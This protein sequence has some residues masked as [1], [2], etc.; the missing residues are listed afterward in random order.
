MYGKV[1]RSPAFIHS[2]NPNIIPEN[3]RGTDEALG[4]AVDL[5]PTL[6]SIAG[7][8]ARPSSTGAIDGI[9]MLSTWKSGSNDSPRK[10]MVYNIDPIGMA[11]TGGNF[12]TGGTVNPGQDTSKLSQLDQTRI[13]TSGNIPESC[14]A[15]RVGKYKLVEGQAGR[16]DWHGTDPSATWTAKYIMGPDATNMNYLNRVSIWRYERDGNQYEI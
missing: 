13:A 11:N 15:I 7:G 5:F 6:L 10:E 3:I 1:Y 14:A 8:S 4:H 9:D 2:P 16:G 12:F